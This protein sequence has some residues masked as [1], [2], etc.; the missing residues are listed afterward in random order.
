MLKSPVNVGKNESVEPAIF[1]HKIDWKVKETF[2][3]ATSN[4]SIKSSAVPPQERLRLDY[5][6]N[7]KEARPEPSHPY[8][9]ASEG[10]SFRSC[11]S[12]A[13]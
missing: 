3:W 5:P 2:D 1:A 4:P 11:L 9:Q 8:E 12:C 6:D 7:T 10:A 13:S